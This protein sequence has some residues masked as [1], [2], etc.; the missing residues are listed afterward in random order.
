M[1]VECKKIRVKWV[2]KT[3][4]NENE[5][6]DKYKARLVEKGYSQQYRICFIE[7]FATMAWLDTIH[8]IIAFAAKKQWTIY[9]LDVKSI[10]LHEK[11]NEEVFVEQPQGHMH[12]GKKQQFYRL[13]KALYELKQASRV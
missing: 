13:K 2:Y 12:K 7:V 4:F 3:K 5:E 11:L 9:Q 1:F 6:A 8:L 10:F